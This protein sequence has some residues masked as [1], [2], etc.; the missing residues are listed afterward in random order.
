MEFTIFTFI[1]LIFYIVTGNY[2][3]KNLEMKQKELQWRIESLENSVV[4]S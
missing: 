1:I 2:K 4:H 3:V